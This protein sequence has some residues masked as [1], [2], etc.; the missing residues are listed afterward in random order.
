MLKL[1]RKIDGIKSQT[2][3]KPWLDRNGYPLSK[4]SL[5]IASRKWSAVTW[6]RYLQSLETQQEE[7]LVKDFSSKLDRF[8]KSESISRE[9]QEPEEEVDLAALERHLEK[10]PMMEKLVIK[11]IFFDGIGEREAAELLQMSRW[12]MRSVKERAI[13]RLR[14][15][16]SPTDTYLENYFGNDITKHPTN[17]L[18]FGVSAAM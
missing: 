8:D 14:S 1:E 13:K 4:A 11:T 2:G 7:I 10:L 3:S 5:E 15:Q 6:E 17:I 18:A 12:L 16:Q 9:R